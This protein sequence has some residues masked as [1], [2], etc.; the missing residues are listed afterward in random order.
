[1]RPSPRWT[2]WLLAGS[3]ALLAAFGAVGCGDDDGGGGGSGAA[4][5]GSAS[6]ESSDVGELA[7]A[8]QRIVD[9][10]HKGNEGDAKDLAQC[11]CIV[12]HFE[13]KQGYDT[14]AKLDKLREE[15]EGGSAD[16]AVTQASGRACPRPA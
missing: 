5:T 7:T 1:M 2:G 3:L 8:R 16:D 12:D 10:C 13:T 6:T 4:T 14:A 9:S 11:K 15:I